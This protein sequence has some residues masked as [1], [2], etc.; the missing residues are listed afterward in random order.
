MDWGSNTDFQKVFDLLLE[1][2]ETGGLEREKMIKRLF[3]FSDME[4]DQAS[5]NQWETDYMVIER[6]FTERGYG[7][8]PQIVFWNLR[9]SRSTPVVSGQEGVALVIGF[10]KNLLKGFMDSGGVINSELIMQEAIAGKLF[11]KLVVVD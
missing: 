9:D 6:K 5:T 7:K 4:F 1:V 3:V 8:P 10:S 11:E 2:A